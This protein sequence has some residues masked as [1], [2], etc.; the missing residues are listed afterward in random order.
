MRQDHLYAFKGLAGKYGPLG[1]HASMLAI[2]A[3]GAAHVQ[4]A[5]TRQL[6][7]GRPGWEC[8]YILHVRHGPP[9]ALLSPAA[10]AAAATAHS[11]CPGR[12]HQ[13]GC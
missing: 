10:Q 12:S 6:L 9:A 1:V 5:L 2:M 3:G 4:P 13:A 11:A 7:G 8:P